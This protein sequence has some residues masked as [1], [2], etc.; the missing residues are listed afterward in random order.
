MN[1]G[2]SKSSIVNILKT[3]QTT[4]KTRGLYWWFVSTSY[5]NVF[6][7]VK[8]LQIS[9]DDTVLVGKKRE[10]TNIYRVEEG[11]SWFFS[12]WRPRCWY[13]WVFRLLLRQLY[14]TD[15]KIL[16]YYF[17]LHLHFDC[18]IPVVWNESRINSGV[19]R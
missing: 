7:L 17:D 15:L 1:K 13:R 5:G 11:Y 10:T 3:W 18:C 2:N 12:Q 8:I 19:S 9:V 14:M 6:P 16:A 4:W